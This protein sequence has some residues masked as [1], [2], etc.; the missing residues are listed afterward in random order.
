M[1]TT[2]AVRATRVLLLAALAATL[3]AC[4]RAEAPTGTEARPGGELVASLRSEPGN[5]N[6]IFEPSAAA[7]LVALL[8]HA[9][10]VRVNRATDAL[11][12]ALAESWQQSPDGAT[13]TLQLRRGVRFADGAPFTSQ[14]VLFSFA[15]AYDAPGSRLAEPIKVAGERVAVSAPD[16]YTVVVRFPTPFAPGARLLDALPILPRHKL[17]PAFQ[18]GTIDKAWTPATPLS[19]ITGLGPFVLTEHAAGQRLVFTRNPHYWRRDERGAPLP[20]LDRLSVAIIPDQNTEALRLEAG[21][22]DLM[23]NG[24]I[25]PD[26]HA[27]FAR[28][29]SQG[30]LRLVDGG[31]GL[32]PN[33]LWFNL[34]SDAGRPA[35]SWYRQPAFRQALSYGVDRQAIAETV[36]FGAAVPIFGPVTPR[37][38]TWY[39]SAAPAY[40]HDPARARRLLAQ[41]GLTDRDGDGLLEDAGGRA[42]RFS[43]LLQQGVT[44]RE[45]TV[46]VLQEQFRRLGIGLDVVGLDLGALVKRW[47][48]GDYD[49]IFHGFQASATDPAMNHDFWLSSGGFHVWNP[50]QKSPAT[51]W[52]TR[53]D[54]LMRAQAAAMDLA[55]RR[56]LFAEVQRIFGEQLPALYFVAP[57]VTLALSPRVVNANP[58]PQIPQLLWSADTL[59]AAGGR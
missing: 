50:G 16:P 48:A 44:T 23:S 33:V 24:D 8:T 49:A 13:L 37:N 47:Q 42:A 12:P 20:Y 26:D 56:R 28:L 30:R 9:R 46:A 4:R 57:K 11:E 10:L 21:A 53:I 38:A 55:E 58:A 2:C 7:D 31:I 59:A 3:P 22:S 43:V 1:A 18:A 32:D 6:R 51:E 52:E 19:D 40:P 17:E 15:V 25:R 39:S 36:Y 29:A 41:S 34:R 5:Y 35:G 45:R 14:D 27:R 54:E